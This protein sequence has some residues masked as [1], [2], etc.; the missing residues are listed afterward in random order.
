MY[1][2]GMEDCS[3]GHF[4]GPAVRDHYLIHYI[5]GG[6]GV[7]QV[8]NRVYYLRKGQGFLICPD[9]VTFYQADWNDPWHYS[10]VGFNGLTAANHLE[11]AGLTQANPIFGDDRDDFLPDCIAQMVA[12]TQIGR[13]RETR[14]KGLLYLFLSKLIEIG[15]GDVSDRNQL[16]KKELYIKKAIEFIRMNYSRQITIK[17]IAA[18]IGLDRSYLCS[19]FK[20]QLHTGPR[21]F[22]IKFRMEK[23]CALMENEALSI[24]DIARSVG[25]DDQLQFSKV[26]RKLNA[27]PPST[28]RK[29]RNRDLD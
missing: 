20:E 11:S 27:L 15:K 26:F 14:L 21:E 1:N 24:G 25:Y 4:Y 22:L 5:R 10:W 16:S 7:F 23:A 13:G 6:K 3:A 2:C 8:G 12:A 19:L 28:F 17:Q 18:Y 29:Q 9:V